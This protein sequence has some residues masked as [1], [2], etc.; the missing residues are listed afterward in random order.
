MNFNPLELLRNAQELQKKLAESQERLGRV[1]AAGSAGGGMVEVTM[2][3]KFEPLAVKIAPE[4]LKP[5][6]SGEVDAKMLEDLTLM[7]MRDAQARVQAIVASELGA[8]ASM[9]GMP[10]MPGA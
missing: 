9:P 5:G 3:G 2:N 6:P 1:S 10:G 8:M 7:A 4:L